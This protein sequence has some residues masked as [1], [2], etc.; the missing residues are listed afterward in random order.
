MRV[1]SLSEIKEALDFDTAVAA[2]KDGFVAFSAGKVT[3]P[4]VGYLGFTDPP[5][6]MH[7][8]YGYIE[9]DDV[10]MVKLATGF[11]NNP[12][13][14]LPSS[15]GLMMVIS[16][17]T[18]EPLALLQDEGYLTD[19]RTA[20]AGA[21][22]CQALAPSGPMRVGIVGT[23]IQANL[24]LECLSKLAN[25]E[26]AF[27]WGRNQSA[28]DAYIENSTIQVEQTGSLQELCSASNVIITTTPSSEPLILP[29]WVQPNTHI[30]A[31]GADAPG[32]QELDA[33][34]LKRADMVVC[35][36]TSQCLHHGEMSYIP[37][38]YFTENNMMELGALLSSD[39]GRPKGAITVA[40]LTGIAAQDIAIA[41][42][43]WERLNA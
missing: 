15:N 26:Q 11:Y 32:K 43:V 34:I 36:S 40:D 35:D 30:T 1:V 38:D 28:V 42:S 9:G 39:Y 6:D 24:Q 13:I 27:L 12:K 4:P 7:I 22:S 18:G 31:V 17:R 19:M 25:I 10:F 3:T 14:G 33:E 2:I 8:K 21:I 23:G 16:A 20:I 41:K 5:G 37:A 29:E